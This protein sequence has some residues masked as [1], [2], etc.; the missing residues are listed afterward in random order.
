MLQDQTTKLLTNIIRVFS[1]KRCSD[2]HKY[3][4]NIQRDG[5]FLNSSPQVGLPTNTLSNNETKDFFR[6]TDPSNC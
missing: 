1:C 2:K 6:M 5:L 4:D 3:E